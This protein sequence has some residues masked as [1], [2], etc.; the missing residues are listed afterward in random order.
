MGGGIAEYMWDRVVNRMMGGV[1]SWGGGKEVSI[2]GEGGINNI[3]LSDKAS[4]NHIILYL[5]KSIHNIYK[6]Y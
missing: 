1:S 6:Y 5:P 4:S 2:E 3:R